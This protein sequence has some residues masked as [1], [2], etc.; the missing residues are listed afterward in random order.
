MSF[1]EGRM[2]F[3]TL[4]K[5]DL[6]YLFDY[7]NHLSINSSNRFGPHTYDLAS[8]QLFYTDP[9]HIGFIVCDQQFDQIIAYS[10]IGMGILPH[11]HSR[12]SSY[13]LTFQ[14]EQ[15]ATLAP[16]VADEWQSR[17]VGSALLHFIFEE[18]KNRSIKR[19]F[20]WGGVQATNEKAINYYHKHDFRILGQFEYHGQN[21]DMMKTL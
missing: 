12:L 13:G 19:I 14:N 16:S 9:A 15:E 2:K 11:D 8:L 10:V 18:L 7:L 21:F 4:V 3:R 20:L 1:P 5:D 17:G 6:P